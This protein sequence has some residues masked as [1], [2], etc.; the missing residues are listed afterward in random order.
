VAFR[1][2]AKALF[3]GRR[4]GEQGGASS[5]YDKKTQVIDQF[6]AKRQGSLVSSPAQ[7]K[8]AKSGVPPYLRQAATK[9]KEQRAE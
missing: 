1:V 2:V 9:G 6:Q 4:A 5:R 3:R 8:V 7:E